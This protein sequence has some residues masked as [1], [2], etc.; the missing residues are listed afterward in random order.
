MKTKTHDV[1]MQNQIFTLIAAGTALILSIPL[2]FT[3]LGSSIENNGF[4][5]GL[6][7][8]IVMGALIFGTGSAFVL[9]A[10]KVR[11]TNYRILIGIGFFMALVAIWSELAVDAVS[12]MLFLI[13]G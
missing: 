13:F 1:L 12:Q 5:W 4:N 3:L 7:D 2:L 9:V 11:D 6:I 8:F 10:R